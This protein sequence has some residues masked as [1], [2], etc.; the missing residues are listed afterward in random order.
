MLASLRAYNPKVEIAIANSIW[1]HRELKVS[2]EFLERNREHFGSEVATVDFGDTGAVDTINEWVATNTKGKIDQIIESI[3]P[4]DVMYLINAI[5][6]NGRWLDI[7]DEE[8]TRER[9]VHLADG[10][11]KQHPMM[12]RSGRYPYLQGAGFQ[13]V[14]LPYTRHDIGMYVFLPDR[15]SSLDQ[16]LVDLTADSW[17]SWM[18]GFSG[19]GGE[20]VLPRFSLEYESLLNSPLT[21]LGMGVAF[22]PNRAEFPGIT[23]TPV[24]ISRVIHKAVV[25]VT[26]EGTEAAAVT[27]VVETLLGGVEEGGAKFTFVVDRPF[28]FAIRDDATGTVLFMGAVYD[29]QLVSN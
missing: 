14:K 10:M 21:G 27:V 7:F 24:Y 1:A 23:P 20:I 6:F 22:D 4:L 8:E 28:F 25:E 26:E 19:G 12:S 5:Y 3:G 17:E 16:F 11:R 29:P 2:P 15:D 13:S 9:T 18:S